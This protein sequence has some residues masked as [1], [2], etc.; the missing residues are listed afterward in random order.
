MKSKPDKRYLVTGAAGFIGFHTAKALLERGE[1]V[2]GIDSFNNYYDV[3]LKQSRH[4]FLV[5][6]YKEYTG[7]QGNITD[8]QS[9]KRIFC[10]YEPNYICHLAAYAGVPYSMQN[11]FAYEKANGLGFIQLME[12]A[13]HWPIKNMVYASSSSVYGNSADCKFQESE[14]TDTPISIY[15]ASKKYNELLAYVYNKNYHIPMTGLRFFTVYGPWGRP[16]MSIFKWTHALYHNQPLILNNSGEMWR[17][18]TYVNDI[19]SGVLSALDKIQSYEIYNLG[20]GAAV[21]IYDVVKYIQEYTGINGNLEMRDLPDGE[22]LYTLSDVS[23]AERDLCYK[24]Q[25]DISDGVKYFIDWYKEYY[26][27]HDC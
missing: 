24:P 1:T 27:K 16:D 10:D 7:I 15:S 6:N 26:G 11:P 9:L 18:Y 21:R 12:I 23:K 14:N 2:I 20:R 4:D 17:D 19:V 3:S 13:R 25:T 5:K 22:V 8:Y